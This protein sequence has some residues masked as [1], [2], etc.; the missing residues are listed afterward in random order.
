MIEITE[1]CLSVD[2]K[3]RYSDAIDILNDMAKVNSNLDWVYEKTNRVYRWTDSDKSV[4]MYKKN[5]LWMVDCKF[6]IEFENMFE[7]FS[8]GF[9]YVRKILKEN[10]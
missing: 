3:K 1:K 5:G 2:P 9:K 4:S 10:C 7:K 6:N 8:D